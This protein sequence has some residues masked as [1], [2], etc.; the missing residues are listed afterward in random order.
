MTS[1]KEKVDPD[2]ST[3]SEK[4]LSKLETKVKALEKEIKELKEK[5][6]QLLV[7]K[8]ELINKLSLTNRDLM[9]ALSGGN[10]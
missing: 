2:K 6:K 8:E 9:F 5:N 3:A 4:G 1:K 10:F 7:E